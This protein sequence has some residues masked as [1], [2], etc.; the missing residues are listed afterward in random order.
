MSKVLKLKSGATFWQEN[1]SLKRDFI[2]CRMIKTDHM[3][4]TNKKVIKHRRP[5]ETKN[6]ESN[7]GRNNFVDFYV[8]KSR[9]KF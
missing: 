2:S 4:S 6:R 9:F 7:Y 1:V 5:N 8:R 3:R